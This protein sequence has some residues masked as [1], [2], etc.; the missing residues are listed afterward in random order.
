MASAPDLFALQ[1]ARYDAPR[2][3]ASTGHMRVL[4]FRHEPHPREDVRRTVGSHGAEQQ[5]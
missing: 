2:R 4:G 3:A 5:L 1:G